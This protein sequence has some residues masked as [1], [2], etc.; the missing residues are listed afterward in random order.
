M[1]KK[2]MNKT[3]TYEHFLFVTQPNYNPWVVVF[4]AV[5][6]QWFNRWTLSAAQLDQEH[7]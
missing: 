2:R 5:F 4:E 3:K 1:H 6:C 7:S